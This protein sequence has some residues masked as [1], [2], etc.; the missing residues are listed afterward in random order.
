MNKFALVL[1]VAAGVVG[2]VVGSQL[3]PAVVHAE[4]TS[5]IRAHKFVLVNHQGDVVGT[6]SLDKNDRPGIRLLENGKEV[7]SAN[8]DTIRQ[9]AIK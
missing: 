3:R 9:L 4:T 7:W 6:F 5:E 1:A 8:G 2:G